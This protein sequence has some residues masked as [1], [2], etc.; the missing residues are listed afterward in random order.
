MEMVLI[1]LTWP[2]NPW[3]LHELGPSL[4]EPK[5]SLLVEDDRINEPIVQDLNGSPSL[6]VNVSDE[7]YLKSLKEAIVI[8]EHLKKDGEKSVFWII[9]EEVRESLLN[10]MNMMYHSRRIRY[11]PRLRQD[12][13]HFLTLKNTPYPHQQIRSIRYFGQHSE[14]A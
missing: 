7:G 1:S 2:A 4:P 9:N 13:D 5:S 12:Q 11:F 6:Q 8:I 3:A 10:L 14:E